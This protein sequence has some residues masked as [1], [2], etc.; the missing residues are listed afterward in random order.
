MNSKKTDSSRGQTACIDPVFILAGEAGIDTESIAWGW[1]TDPNCLRI[2]LNI[3]YDR[4]HK[5]LWIV[6]NGIGWDDKVE[7]DGSIHDDYRI[8]YLR[9]NISSMHDAV[10]IDGVNLT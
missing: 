6:E 1:G 7:E 3:L 9:Q 5:P 4:Y 10:T 2:V 8:D